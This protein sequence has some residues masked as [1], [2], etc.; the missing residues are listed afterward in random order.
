M[1]IGKMKKYFINKREKWLTTH[2]DRSELDVG[3]DEIG[4]YVFM[5]NSWGYY[6]KV[7]LPK[8]IQTK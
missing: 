7:Y 8:E 4:E 6:K 1:I 5:G 2:G 3:R